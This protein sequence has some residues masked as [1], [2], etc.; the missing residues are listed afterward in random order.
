MEL[1]LPTSFKKKTVIADSNGSLKCGTGSAAFMV[2]SATAPALHPIFGALL[3]PGV[4]KDGDSRCCGLAGIYG[5]VT[6]IQC[7]VERYS[8][9]SSGVHV[10]CDNEQALHIFDPDFLPDPQ[11]N[12]IDLVNAL[13]YLLHASPLQWTCKHIKGHQDTKWCF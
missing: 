4:V 10:A 3:I 11:H 6:L 5:I 9:T 8:I 12:N 7:V 1:W 13:F 2:V